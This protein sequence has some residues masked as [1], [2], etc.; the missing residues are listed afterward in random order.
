MTLASPLSSLHLYLG[1]TGPQLIEQANQQP[2]PAFDAYIVPSSLSVFPRCLLKKKKNPQIVHWYT[3]HGMVSFCFEV[4]SAMAMF[5]FIDFGNVTV[6]VK[7]D[8]NVDSIS[9][10]Y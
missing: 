10:W 5:V 9:P 8:R 4:F 2:G 1:E 7:D 3:D 6:D